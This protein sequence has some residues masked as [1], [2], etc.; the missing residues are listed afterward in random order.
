MITIYANWTGNALASGATTEEA[1]A[2]IGP[3]LCTPDTDFG[4]GPA[5][6]TA[7]DTGSHPIEQTGDSYAYL[8][9]ARAFFPVVRP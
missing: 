5:D 7:L 8:Y 2:K 9:V 3:G 6:L 4:P 1:R